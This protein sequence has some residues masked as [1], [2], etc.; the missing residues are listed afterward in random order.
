MAER[1]VLR[2][3]EAQAAESVAAAVEPARTELIS[4]ATWQIEPILAML[5]E[6]VDRTDD[7]LLRGIL[8][9]LQQLNH[10]IMAA[11]GDHGLTTQ[12]IRQEVFGRF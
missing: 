3:C 1:N 11:A 10:A 2:E 4:Q 12:Q 6:H 7:M 5:A 8:P 9:R